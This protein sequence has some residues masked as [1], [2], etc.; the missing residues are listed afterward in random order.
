MSKCNA[1]MEV[2]LL[3][4]MC[5][6][7]IRLGIISSDCYCSLSLLRSVTSSDQVPGVACH[8][9]VFNCLHVLYWGVGVRQTETIFPHGHLRHIC[10]RHVTVEVLFT[11]TP[12]RR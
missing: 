3:P 1:Y 11:T 8:A 12:L 7:W 10:L 5:L 4:L 6:Q 9:P 2:L